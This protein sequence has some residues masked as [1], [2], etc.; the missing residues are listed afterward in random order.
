MRVGEKLP[1][2]IGDIV[3]RVISENNPEK[4]E[5][6]VG[7]SVYL[8]VFHPLSIQECVNVSGFDM[9]GR[10]ELEEKSLESEEKYQ[11]LFDLIE[12][13]V[14]IGE[15]IFDEKGQPIDNIILDINLAYEKLSGL[16][17]EQVIGRS[18]KETF[19][20]IEQTWLDRYVEVVRTGMGTHFEE[21]NA[22]LDRW[23][24]VFTSPMGGNRFIAVFSDITKRKQT[25]EDLLQSE[26]HSRLLYETMLQGVV[27]QDASGKIISMNPQ[28]SVFL[29]RPQ[30]SSWAALLWV[31]R[32]LLS[33][34]MAR[35]FQ[36]SSIHLWYPCE[37][38]R[39]FR[40]W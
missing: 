19:P 9:S 10:K 5:V 6:K 2:S 28:Q 12:Q 37:Q 32:I 7:K 30:L 36:E 20:T 3:R 34:R 18:L 13:A 24:E 39:K 26:Q 15:I 38:G 4:M 22:S 31:E 11:D 40:M 21:H 29:A 35:R 17:R 23:F 8:V 33:G 25:E 1:S 27:Y 16:R 14:Q